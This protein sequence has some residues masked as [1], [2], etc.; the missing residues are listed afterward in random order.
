MKRYKKFYFGLIFINVIFIAGVVCFCLHLYKNIALKNEKFDSL[1]SD[2]VKNS[3]KNNFDINN[4][5]ANKKVIEFYNEI[6]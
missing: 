6:R 5:K 2:L 1:T 3:D 4:I